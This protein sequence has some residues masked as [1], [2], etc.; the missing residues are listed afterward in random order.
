MADVLLEPVTE[1]GTAGVVDDADLR[2]H[3]QVLGHRILRSVDEELDDI[4]VESATHENL[5]GETNEQRKW[6][7][8]RRMRLDDYGVT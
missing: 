3:H 8:G 2:A 4:R 1:R 5:T 6:E 7:D